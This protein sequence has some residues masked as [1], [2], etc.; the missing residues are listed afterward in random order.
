VCGLVIV[1]ICRGKINSCQNRN[2]V[3][4]NAGFREEGKR[5]N[6]ILSSLEPV[7]LKGH[8]TG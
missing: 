4:K 7:F 8:E 3:L 6:P 5:G 1:E 2:K